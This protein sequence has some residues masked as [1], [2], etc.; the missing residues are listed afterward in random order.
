[1]T[2]IWRSPPIW[3][4]SR[5][6]C[7][8]LGSVSSPFVLRSARIL[9]MRSPSTGVLAFGRGRGL[10]AR[11]GREREERQGEGGE[12]RDT[13]GAPLL[14]EIARESPQDTS[15]DDDRLARTSR[16]GEELGGAR[17]GAPAWRGGVRP[18]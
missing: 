12:L 3:S 9:S 16:S 15:R 18:R 17:P 14:V 11:A 13:Q 5:C 2:M 7:F 4:S 10:V 8:S 6:S 1:M